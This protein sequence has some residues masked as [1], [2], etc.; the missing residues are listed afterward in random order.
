MPLTDRISDAGEESPE[1]AGV[2][3]RARVRTAIAWLVLLTVAMGLRVGLA[4]HFPNVF[5]PDEIFQTLEPAHRLAYGYGVISWEWRMGVRSWVL[6]ALLA[7]AMRTTGWL[8]SGAT[9]YLYGLI[10]L[11]SLASLSAVWFGYAWAKRVSGKEAAAVAAGASAVFLSLVYFAPKAMNELLATYVLLPGLYLG[12]YAD[13]RNERKRLFFAGILCGLAASL[14]MQLIPAAVFAALCFCH[15]CWRRRIPT[16]ATGLFLPVLAFGLVDGMTWSY[17]WQSFI[18]YFQINVFEGKSAAFGIKPWY[19]YLLILAALLGPVVVFLWKGARRTPFL[20][21]VSLI[22]LVSHSLLGHK[23]IRFIFLILPLAITMASI[24]FVESLA[25]ARVRWKLPEFSRKVVAS[26]VLCFALSS[27]FITPKLVSTWCKA[28]GAV[29]AFDRLSRD[30][31]LCGVALDQVLWEKSGGYT[32][33]HRNVPIL[34]VTDSASLAVKAQAFNAIVAPVAISGLPAGYKRDECWNGI[35]VYQRPGACLA[36]Q[37][38]D[39]LNESLQKTG[40]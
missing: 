17:P 16:V 14:R 6:P 35:C 23:E 22:I 1:S 38:E 25:K 20:A 28:P 3:R 36:P 2:R 34:R 26:G 8:G 9:G 13:G 39:R 29:L 40:E 21:A 27:A 32:H 19:W 18:R 33:L 37:P 10:V 5:Y 31:S 30:S 4:V 7:G 12:M 24:G 11:L 15:P